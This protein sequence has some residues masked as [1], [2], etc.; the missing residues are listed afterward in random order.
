MSGVA[1]V[2][3]D[4]LEDAWVSV[5]SA[6][7]RQTK[8]DKIARGRS[9]LDI[10]DHRLEA[11]RYEPTVAEVIQKLSNFLGI[12]GVDLPMEDL[13]LLRENEEKALEIIRR[14][15]KILALRASKRVKQIKLKLGVEE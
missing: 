15:P 5:L 1:V 8:W 3:E 4:R 2:S 6:I 14:W 12:Q 9:R 10:F 11:S 7:Y 13:Q